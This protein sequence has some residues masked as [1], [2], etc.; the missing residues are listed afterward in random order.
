MENNIQ[1]DIARHM[2]D[3]CGLPRSSDI[4]KPGAGKEMKE[5]FYRTFFDELPELDLAAKDDAA[6]YALR[7]L[8]HFNRYKNWIEKFGSLQNIVDRG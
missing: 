2:S 3:L 4:N 7:W 5:R 8:G 1:A 6:I